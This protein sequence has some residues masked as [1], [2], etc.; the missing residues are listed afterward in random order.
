MSPRR[1]SRAVLVLRLSS[2]GDILLTQPVLAAVRSAGDEVDLAVRPEHADLARLLPGVDRVLTGPE[3]ARARYD[4]CL[5]LH[6][7]ARSRRWLR[8]V[9]SGPVFR[10]DKRALARR[11]LVRP[12]GRRVP[13]NRWS[14]LD[15][16]ASVTAWYA[17]AAV[18]A[19]YPP[20]AAPPH[21]AV[22]AAARSAARALLKRLGLRPGQRYA[23]LAPGAKWPS[24]QWPQ[25]HYA[26]LAQDLERRFGLVSVFVGHPGEA[27]L[28]R[29]SAAAAGGRAVTTAGATDL[30]VLA[31]LLAD[32]ELAVTN[33]SGPLHLAL[34][35]GT[36]GL[37]FF[38]PTVP[39]FGFAPSGPRVRV[40]SL[41]LPCRPCSLHGGRACPLGHQRCLRGITPEDACAAA[42]ELLGST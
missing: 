37:A 3:Q 2:L 4:L 33:D 41:D 22:P 18:R 19:G 11:L 36:K 16:P 30:P 32:A 24:K 25:D 14:G 34:A 9:R 7:S 29:D 21:V 13:W 39:E 23:V 28:C 10:Y 31:A 6:A 1:P 26:R 40:L 27:E 17:E 15:R 42:E 5:D 8:R 38:G 12:G 20:P 35:A